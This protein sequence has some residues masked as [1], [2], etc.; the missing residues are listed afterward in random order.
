MNFETA[1]N[2]VMKW[3]GGYVNDPN[4]PGGETAFGI[5]KRAYPELEIKHL[6][7]KMAREIYLRDYWTPLKCED[8]IPEIRLLV[9]D[10]G[11]H[12]GLRHAIVMLQRAVKVK[13]DGIYGPMTKRALEIT[14]P[15]VVINSYVFQRLDH[16]TNLTGWKNFS[17]GW[18]KRVL[19][20]GMISAFS[21]PLQ[22]RDIKLD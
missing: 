1:F 16:L 21:L 10:A 13:T 5:S 18:A 2:Y 9:F 11:V 20:V 17:K 6:T 19:E 14:P 12:T 22:G 15:V 3:E 8:M 4:D 7:K